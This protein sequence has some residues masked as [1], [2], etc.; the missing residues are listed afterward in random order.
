MG[1]G[2][3]GVQPLPFKSPSQA[4]I[5]SWPVDF[6]EPNYRPWNDTPLWQHTEAAHSTRDPVSTRARNTRRRTTG[7]S[8]WPQAQHLTQ[9]QP[10]VAGISDLTLPH[11]P[12]IQLSALFD[13]QVKGSSCLARCP[14]CQR[15]CSPL[16]RPSWGLSSFSHRDV[17]QNSP[18][19]WRQSGRFCSNSV[20]PSPT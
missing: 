2:R 7:K 9:S 17:G 12:L 10:D 5:F 20:S 11:P 3:E 19:R 15:V 4:P 6:P 1:G 14:E 8:V 16:W 13:P 18:R